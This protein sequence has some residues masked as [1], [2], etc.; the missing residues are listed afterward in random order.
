MQR[1]AFL[2]V[3]VCALLSVS[4]TSQVPVGHLQPLGS[5]RPADKEIDAYDEVISPEEFWE[6]YAS[7]R[8]PVVFRGAGRHSAAMGLW[9]DEYLSRQYGRLEVKLEGK[10]EKLG[11][12]PV[13]EVGVGRDTIENFLK[14]YKNEDKYIV[15]QLPEPM[16]TQVSVLPCLLCGTFKRRL[17]E[18]N[19]WVSSGGSRSLLHRDADNAINCLLH[20]RKDWIM[21]DP[22]Y[23]DF[24]SMAEENEGAL[25]GFSLVNVDKVNLVRHPDFKKVHW[26]YSNLSAGDCIF[27]PYGHF[28][29]VRS[30]ERN[31]AVSVL[32]ARLTEF[33]SQPDC[34]D[35]G[36][37]PAWDLLSNQ[38]VA[39]SYPGHGE[40]SMG[41]TDPEHIRELL[42]HASQ[43]SGKG[44]IDKQLFMEELCS[45]KELPK[46]PPGQTYGPDFE[47]CWTLVDPDE[48]GKVTADEISS[49]ADAT[50]KQLTV[51]LEQDPANMP[52][53]EYYSLSHEAVRAFVG[54]VLRRKK[55]VSEKDFIAEYS[56][57]LDGSEVFGRKLFARLDST[58]RG[59][60]TEED[61]PSSSS[62]VF[63]EYYRDY[64][65]EDMANRQFEKVLRPELEPEDIEVPHNIPRDE[66]EPDDGDDD[67]ADDDDGA[68]PLEED[69][70]VRFQSTASR[71]E[72]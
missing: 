56:L 47:Q 36:S 72:L 13:G 63:D 31:V 8:K 21:V 66:S 17:L 4:G 9:T 16:Y 46:R 27:I 68:S 2:A 53:Y 64:G 67:D 48:D 34:P 35:N 11:K 24:V 10:R 5:H 44:Y 26:T 55:S 32:F 23:D 14:T 37:L 58:G 6:K 54:T 71:T 1:S 65:K 49:M 12:M 43:E 25:G 22:A 60:L 38:H 30:Y 59:Y 3:T 57:R 28:H 40:M 42:L 62:N 61:I 50:L 19:L 39:W 20:G 18:V 41:N 29:Q 69:S 70:E 51:F 7:Q 15:S 52:D 45:A 33:S